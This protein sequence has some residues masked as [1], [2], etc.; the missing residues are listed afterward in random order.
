MNGKCTILL[1]SEFNIEIHT[2]CCTTMEQP[3][4]AF[5]TNYALRNV[6]ERLI[7][8]SLAWHAQTTPSIIRHLSRC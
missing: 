5:K 2:A 3:G 6:G 8:D 4:K 7:N 1:L